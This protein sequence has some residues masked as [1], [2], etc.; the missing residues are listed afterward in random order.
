[1]NYSVI[2]SRLRSILIVIVLIFP[3]VVKAFFVDN[4]ISSRTG[5]SWLGAGQVLINDAFV[6]GVFVLLLYFSF[7][8][9]FGRF[10]ALSIRFLSF[11]IF[12]LYAIDLWVM[13][14]FN[15][16][17]VVADVF[18]YASYAP[19]YFHHIYGEKGLV[20]LLLFLFLYFLFYPFVFSKSFI[21]RRKHHASAWL[22]IFVMLSSPF[23]AGADE[24]Y[25][26]SWVYKN[27]I[28]YNITSLTE[29]KSYSRAFLDS[30]NYIVQ[31]N[32]KEGR[33]ERK[34][35]IML[36][37]ESLSPYQS[38]YFSGIK[39]WM[40]N[41]DN[42]ASN[43][44]AFKNF[45]ANGFTTED[46]E[47]SLLLGMLPIHPPSSFT[48]GGGIS[49][50]GYF[51]VENSLPNVLNKLNYNTEF[52]TT[53]DLA[54]ANTGAWATSIGFSYV[55]G[56]ES[57]FYQGWDRY[58]FKSVPDEALYLR[59]LDRI[60]D[61]V[62]ENFFIFIK[63]VS[64]HHPFIN[65]DNK[66]RS[67]EE[68]FRYSDKQI[69]VFY[70]KLKE[71]GFFNNGILIIVGDHHSMVPLKKEELEGMGELRAAAKI[72]M[73]ISFGDVEQAEITELFQQTDV[74]NSLIGY[75]SPEACTSPWLGN[76]FEKIPPKFIAHRRGDN[77]NMISVFV[78]DVDVSV[79]L[80]GDNTRIVGSP[81]LDYQSK[82]EI[83]DKINHERITKM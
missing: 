74:Y 9:V 66:I 14:N 15:S 22:T 17:L 6:Y 76:F 63:S 16:H 26:H 35:I 33:G 2:K 79:V 69:G 72:P 36:M 25:V 53:A 37:V 70:N 1:M 58:H 43:N 24:R 49:F 5:V 18:K 67:E 59:V 45:Y 7:L 23:V 52:L 47:I 65:P 62:Q 75:I 21:N 29:S 68:A 64:T 27:F 39:D 54:F 11:F 3:L 56:H 30:H 57:T 73:I 51:D 13:M 77:R 71:N 31:N 10:F 8:N 61:N 32:C 82:K 60:K 78:N 38:K 46:G 55:E 34:D 44:L 80:D 12:S 4:H 40:P 48:I 81:N 28:S 20:L 50:N 83:I 19:K 41:I 42:I